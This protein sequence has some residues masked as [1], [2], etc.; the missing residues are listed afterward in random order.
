MATIHK[1]TMTPGKVELLR[2]WLPGQPWYQGGEPPE[3]GRGGGFRLD[4]P[5]G[6]GGI[7][8]SVVI[9]RSGGPAVAYLIPLTYRSAA[10]PGADDALIGTAVHGVLGDRWIYDGTRDP[11]LVAALVALI[12]GNAEPQAAGVSDTPDSTVVSRPATS[13]PLT[14]IAPAAVTDSVAATELWLG[15]QRADGSAA[16]QLFVLVHRVLQADATPADQDN[17]PG[18]SGTWQLPDE[19]QGR[20]T[21]ITAEYTSG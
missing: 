21:F 12:Q 17:L 7:E 5:A 13:E 8:F 15:V 10:L 4:D 14:V 9:D 16:G 18:V 6:G 20:G 3:L 2:N 11:V 19:T 1:T